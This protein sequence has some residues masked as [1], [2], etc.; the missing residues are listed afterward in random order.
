LVNFAAKLAT[1]AAARRCAHTDSLL[2]N[3]PVLVRAASNLVRTARNSVLKI[4]HSDAS[5]EYANDLCV[6]VAN[7]YQ[8]Q[9]ARR[10]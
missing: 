3:D 8:L 5:R 9:W 6:T 1:S 4:D 2:R 7:N 10:I